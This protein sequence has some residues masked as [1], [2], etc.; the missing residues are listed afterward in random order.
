MRQEKGSPRGAFRLGGL[1]VRPD[2]NE[3]S[4]DGGPVRVGP[5]AMDVLLALADRPDEVVTKRELLEAVWTD[6]YVGDEVLSTAVWELRRAMGDDARAPRLIQTVPRRGYRLLVAPAPLEPVA[7]VADDPAERADATPP[8]AAAAPA[9]RRRLSL[10]T[11]VLPVVLAA[12]AAVVVAV[13]LRG[14]G[15][16]GGPVR[17]LAVLPFEALGGGPRDQALADGVTDTLITALARIDGLRVVSRTTALTYRDSERT[18]PEI[19]RELG[20]DVVVEGTLARQGDRIVL[21]AQLIDGRGEDHL[22]AETYERRFEHLLDLQVEVARSI[23]AAIA[24]R[25]E[26]PAAP[27]GRP[28]TAEAVTGSLLRWRFATGGEIWSGPVAYR[29]TV[30]FGSR[31]GFLYAV[32][33]ADGAE[34]WRVRVGDEVV[35]APLVRDGAVF[36]AAHEG[37]VAAIDARSGAVR[38]RHRLDTTTETG[39][40]ARAG[41]VVVADEG[42]LVMALDATSGRRLWTWRGGGGV[43][44]VAVGGERVLVSRFDGAV[45][46]L[47]AVDGAQLWTTPLGDF[48]LHPVL[49]DGDR[50][51]VPDPAG[52]VALALEDGAERWRAPVPAPSTP[53]A[54]RDR[55]VVGGAGEAVVVLD[56]SSGAELWRHEAFGEV[57]TP[58]VVDDLVVAGSHDHGVYGLD[59]W[60]GGLRWRIERRTW[61]TTTPLVLDGVVVLGG[62]DGVVTAVEVPPPADGPLLVSEESGYRASPAPPGDR[63]RGFDV[64]L[65]DLSRVRPRV[66]WRVAADGPVTLAPAFGGDTLYVGGFRELV[67]L[68]VAGGAERWRVR[69]GGAVGTVPLVLDDLVVAGGRDGSVL[70]LDRD[71]GRVRWRVQ[72]AGDVLTAPVAADGA[73]LFGSRDGYLYAVGASDGAERWRRQLDVIHGSPAVAGELVL[74]PSRNDTLWAVSAAGGEIVWS[75]PT[76]D[77]AVS[78]PVVWRDLVLLG[79]CDGVFQAFDLATGAE[80]WRLATGGDIW[81]RPMVDAGRVYFGSG[82]HHLYAADAATG[83]ELWRRRTGN[84]VWSSVARWRDLVIAGSHDRRLWALD[85]AT[86]EPAWR[87]ATTGI[88]GSPAVAG[89]LL[90]VGGHD[91][92][93]YLLELEPG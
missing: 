60:T 90:A 91:G 36:A 49:V 7:A 73:V 46:A 34:R 27:S 40:A 11:L 82:D 63:R 13:Q 85:G 17:A 24:E 15:R 8:S 12:L 9:P 64:V 25:I 6:L 47:D 41:T 55:I 19:A 33:V 3:I 2:L 88:M 71:D 62:L 72:T 84:R 79:S 20:V 10:R 35:G 65:D 53:A 61:V 42:E 18:V 16:A 67:A 89:D 70:A 38:W 58:A 69:F 45:T 87:L 44:G 66:R 51:L 4:G 48:Q 78:D 74:V 14:S 75:A 93:V 5:R 77:W 81:F 22:W 1:V 52:V 59:P 83:R 37:E 23:G 31:D 21:N 54:W 43:V 80:R 76:S 28:T 86:G 26:P 50:V 68:E 32:A 92:Y 30:L 56:R 39:L 29:D 57:R